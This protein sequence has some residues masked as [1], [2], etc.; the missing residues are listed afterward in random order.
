MGFNENITG[1]DAGTIFFKIVNLSG[2]QQ[3]ITLTLDYLPL[4]WS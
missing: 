2:A 1:P 4:E 3:Q